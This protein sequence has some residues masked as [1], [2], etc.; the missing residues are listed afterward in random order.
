MKS[1]IYLSIIGGTIFVLVY[2]MFFTKEFESLAL[3][4]LAVG[5]TA[6]LCGRIYFGEVSE[7]LK[8]TR[9]PFKKIVHTRIVRRDKAILTIGNQQ[10]KKEDI[11]LDASVFDELQAGDPVSVEHSAKSHM[12]FSIKRI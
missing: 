5:I 3:L 4:Y 6:V 2:F 11:L 7:F 10:F 1:F 8:E 12:I 9:S